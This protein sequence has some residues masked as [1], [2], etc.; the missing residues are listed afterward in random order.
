ME[1]QKILSTQEPVVGGTENAL[2]LGFSRHRFSR[3]FREE[4]LP[5]C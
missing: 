2:I 5:G 1:N 4:T 3:A